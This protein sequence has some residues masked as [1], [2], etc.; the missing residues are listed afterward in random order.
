MFEYF[1]PP[2]LDRSKV[3]VI[4]IVFCVMGRPR[5][6]LHKKCQEKALDS[7]KILPEKI[8]H[9]HCKGY[10]MQLNEFNKSLV[11]NESTGDKVSKSSNGTS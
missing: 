9:F 1:F 6:R 5:A 8:H 2:N 11:L 3:G 10:I 7:Q 4:E